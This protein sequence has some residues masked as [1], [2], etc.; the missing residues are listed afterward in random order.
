MSQ[1]VSPPSF[2]FQQEKHEIKKSSC[3]RNM[4]LL[5]SSQLPPSQEAPNIPAPHLV[6][7]PSHKHNDTGAS[8][9]P[10]GLN[11]QTHA[12]LMESNLWRKNT[13]V[14]ICESLPAPADG[15]GIESSNPTF[16]CLCLTFRPSVASSFIYSLPLSHTLTP[17]EKRSC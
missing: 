2:I 1:Y 11:R 9:G 17:L 3:G 4:L 14:V 6:P 5:L 7:S 8:G 16:V 12:T 10:Y 13:S 15:H